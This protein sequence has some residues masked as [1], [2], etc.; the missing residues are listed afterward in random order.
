MALSHAAVAQRFADARQG[1][2]SALTVG[3]YDAGNPGP[4]MHGHFR[5]VATA[6]SYATQIA[7]LVDNEIT[8]TRE[9]D[10][11]THAHQHRHHGAD[12]GGDL[13]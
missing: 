13:R 5:V 4:T 3:A 2:G 12:G 7:H 1:K 11:I 9:H 6:W 8:G 10:R